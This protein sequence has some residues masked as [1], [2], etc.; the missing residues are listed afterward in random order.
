M[1]NFKLTCNRQGHLHFNGLPTGVWIES[2]EINCGKHVWYLQ[3][4]GMSHPQFA[5]HK[6]RK[7]VMQ[8]AHVFI[9]GLTQGADESPRNAAIRALQ[10]CLETGSTNIVRLRA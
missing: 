4:P 7:D 8:A 1:A 2:G 9:E 5:C 6:R 10:S 3:R